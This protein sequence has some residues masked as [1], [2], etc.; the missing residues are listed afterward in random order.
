MC[1]NASRQPDTVGG[2]PSDKGCW[3]YKGKYV[4]DCTKPFNCTDVSLTAVLEESSGKYKIKFQ[5]DPRPSKFEVNVEDGV[6]CTGT[7]SSK[8]YQGRCEKGTCQPVDGIENEPELQ[9]VKGGWNFASDKKCIRWD[10]IKEKFGGKQNVA[11]RRLKCASL[12]R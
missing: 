1:I 11:E 12:K 3:Y 7:S 5:Y 4:T 6:P 8:P 9:A 10:K 2:I